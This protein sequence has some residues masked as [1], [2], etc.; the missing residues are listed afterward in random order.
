MTWLWI[1]LAV[2]I[3]VP[4][5]LFAIGSFLP[6]DH[7]ARMS[8]EL[9]APPDRIWT[10]V[11]D[12]AGTARWRKDISAVTVE[13]A[14][15]GPVRYVEQSS[16]GKIPFEIVSQDP[17][18]RQVVRV[19]DDDQPFGGTWTWELT[20][21]AAGTRIT[22]TEAGFVKNPLFRVMSKLVFKPTNTIRSYLQA[23]ARELGEAAE[24]REVGT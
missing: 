13:S 2:V 5:I 21:A 22:I 24:P 15:G 3:G 14:P 19:V 1:V 6:R 20:P 17:P 16:H 23:L 4:L 12:L 8:I 10:L 7:V 9:A 11:S 18:R